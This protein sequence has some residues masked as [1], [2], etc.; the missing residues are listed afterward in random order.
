MNYTQ[1]LRSRKYLYPADVAQIRLTLS[2]RTQVVAIAAAISGIVSILAG[3]QVLQVIQ[4]A[5]ALQQGANAATSAAQSFDPDQVA[6]AMTDLQAAADDLSERTASPTWRVLQALPVVGQGA[7]ALAATA[8][9]TGEVAEAAQPLLQV[10][11]AHDSSIDKAIAV[12]QARDEVDRLATAV[13]TANRQLADYRDL[14]L[15][16]GLGSQLTTATDVLDQLAGATAAMQDAVGPIAAMAGL[17]GPK[18]WLVMAQNP[19]EARGSGGLFN[20]YLI[21]RVDRGRVAIVEAGSRKKLDREFPRDEQIPYLDTIDLDTANSWGPVLGEWAS[22][23]LPRDFP[24]VATLAEA[25]MAKRGTPVDGVIAIDPTVVQ[26]ILAGTGPVEHQGVTIDGSNAAEF[27]TKGLYEDFPGFNSVRK[28]DRLAMG[29]VYATVDAALKRP[30]D[31]GSLWPQISTAIADG[32]LKVWTKQPAT[33]A[34]IQSTPLAG[35]LRSKADEVVISTNNG[36]GGK[37]DPYL[38]ISTMTDAAQCASA[39]RVTTKIR[40]EN[41]VPPDLPDYVDVT[42]DQDGQPDPSIPKGHTLTYLTLYPPTGWELAHASVGDREA[43]PWDMFE[44]GRQGW[45]IPVTL[46]RGEVVEIAV[47]WQV[48]TCPKGPPAA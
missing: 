9:A 38:S 35:S 15:P 44:A 18:T 40:M 5:R 33:Q 42:L 20:A 3:Y 11:K 47:D 28:K 16:M 31:L 24:T 45:L 23:N 17:D 12:L 27:F 6:A 32:H 36:T 13:D 19:A 37:L 2:R 25:G 14:S 4:G 43:E 10:V 21:V 26:A 46:L 29:L 34:W 41:D 22:F 48:E 30:L 8:Q 1:G 39:R 7:Q